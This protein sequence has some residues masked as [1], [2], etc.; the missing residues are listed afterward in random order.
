M[1]NEITGL[2]AEETHKVEKQ[3]NENNK[4]HPIFGDILATLFETP[5]LDDYARRNGLDAK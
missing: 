2:N 1:N 5:T 4:I 3:L